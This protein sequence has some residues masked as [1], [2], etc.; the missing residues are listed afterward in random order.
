MQFYNPEVIFKGGVKCDNAPTENT[1]LVRKQDVAGLS[2]ID[3]I[4]DG[5]S[6]MLT[7]SGG[8]LSI[9]NLALT[10]VHVDST[11]SSLA[12]FITNQSSTAASL[13]TGDVLILTAPSAGTETFM[14]SGANGSVAGNYTEIESPLSAAEV[15]AVINAGDG[16]SVNAANAT[17]SANIEAG[18]GLSKSVSGGQITFAVNASSDQISEGSSNLYY[19][20]SRSRSAVSLESVAGP[21]SNLMKYN[22]STGEFKVLLSDVVSEFSAGTGLA[23]DGGG[24]FSLSANTD[25]VSEG[26]SNLYFTQARSRTAIS[27]GTGISYNNS[28]G[29]FAIS[30]TG[31]AGIGISGSTISFNGSTSDVSEGSNQY[32]TQ[33]RARASIQADPASGNLLSYANASGDLLV[34]TASVRGAF[35][36]G[37]AIG[38][39]NGVIS[40]N[41]STSDVSEGSN[42]YHT[43]ARVRSAVSLESVAGPD[44]N[45]MKYNNSTGKFKVLL[46]DVVSEFSAGTGLAYDG[47]GGFSL[48]ANTDQV[49]EGSSNLYH[50]PARVRAAVS[51]SSQADELIGYDSSN[52]SFSLRLQELRHEQSITLSA[53]TAATITHNLG[54]QLVHVSSMDASGNKIELETVYLNNTSLSVK[55][56]VGITVTIAIS[57]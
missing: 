44:S 16:I 27:G 40:F 51:V 54:K 53:N 29:A 46:S 56:V 14:V 21:D 42:L 38:L 43:D 35:S 28:T 11:Q 22:S 5:S 20:D 37:T 13:Q 39:S 23:H 12:N 47:G 50:T 3:G 24:G 26:S 2:F 34:S 36:G 33:S 7:V 41:G 18:T 55:S 17:I 8:K 10:D 49:S 57:V 30:L 45:L 15:G 6:S 4:A 48:S 31:G 52:G 25:Q 9:S 1:H 32:F 19:T